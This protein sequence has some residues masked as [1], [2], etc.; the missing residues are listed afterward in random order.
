MIPKMS[1]ATVPRSI[2][3]LDSFLLTH[4]YIQISEESQ[5][6]VLTDLNTNTTSHMATNDIK[7]TFHLTE[8]A[9][10]T[11]TVKMFTDFNKIY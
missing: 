7:K 10:V 2:C 9:K 5:M 1:Q 4:F 11:T 6:F 8:K 3:I